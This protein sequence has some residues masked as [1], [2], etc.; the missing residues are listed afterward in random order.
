MD[1]ISAFRS[2]TWEELLLLILPLALQSFMNRG[3]FD[4]SPPH[5][6][7]SRAFFH[8][9]ST[10]NNLTFFKTLSSQLNLGL[11][12][13]PRAFRLRGYLFAR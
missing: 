10:F 11:V 6:F 1:M 5:I 2:Y 7:L 8:H 12:L 3:L 4:D 9:I 13:F